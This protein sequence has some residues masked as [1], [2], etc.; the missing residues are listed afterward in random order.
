MALQRD[1]MPALARQI[2]D[3]FNQ[4]LLLRSDIS[5]LFNALEQQGQQLKK[6]NHP[7]EN[8]TLTVPIIETQ[9]TLRNQMQT[10][11][12]DFADQKSECEAFLAGLPE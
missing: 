3:L 1:A 10:T 11:R 7:I 6:N 12:Q 5:I 2:E 9:D 4:L 8:N